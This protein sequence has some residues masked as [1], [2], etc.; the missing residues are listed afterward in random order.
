[1]NPTNIIPLHN[2]SR[3]A[4]TALQFA[5]DAGLRVSVHCGETPCDVNYNGS[6]SGSAIY[7]GSGSGN[8]N[9]IDN[10]LPPVT[11]KMTKGE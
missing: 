6:G 4:K 9:G 10:V 3:S 7:N 1:M 8:R 11:E 2:S 5:R